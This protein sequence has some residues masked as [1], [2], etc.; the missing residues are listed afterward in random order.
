MS[1]HVQRGQKRK[2]KVLNALDSDSRRGRKGRLQDPVILFH[3]SENLRRTLTSWWPKLCV[4]WRDAKTP[5]EIAQGW[6]GAGLTDGEHGFGRLSAIAPV[7]L[8]VVREPRFWGKKPATQI[9]HLADSLAAGSGSARR[10]RDVVG[11]ARKAAAEL[12][13]YQVETA[14]PVWRIQCSCGRRGLSKN[15]ACAKCGA[16]IPLALLMQWKS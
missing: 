11:R 10:S 2:K 14:E 1:A 16:A 9:R 13:R 12:N 15:M 7:I 3:R 6:T 8:S 4:A 5:E